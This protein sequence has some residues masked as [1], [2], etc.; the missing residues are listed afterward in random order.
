MQLIV[1][2]GS[3]ALK[4]RTHKGT[5]DKSHK[6]DALSPSSLYVNNMVVR[7]F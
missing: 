2:G 5:L 1:E 6:D 3:L 4:S 7:V